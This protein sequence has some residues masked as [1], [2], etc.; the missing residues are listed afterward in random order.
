MGSEGDYLSEA[1]LAAWPYCPI[2]GCPNKCCKFLNSIYCWPHTK[3]DKTPEDL[4][5]ELN[6]KHLIIWQWSNK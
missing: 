1:E 2:A 6:K 4:M 3:A 5:E